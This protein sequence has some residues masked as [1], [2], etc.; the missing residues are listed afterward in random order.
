[1]SDSSVTADNKVFA[2]LKWTNRFTIY[3]AKLDQG[4]SHIASSSRFTL[5][6]TADQPLDWSPDGNTLILYSNR[7]GSNGIYKQSLQD[8]NPHLLVS[9]RIQSEARVT[10]D[11]KWVL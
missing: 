5:S 4:G 10:P 8:D 1:M 9:S 6:E 2:F 11:G 3:L 7:S